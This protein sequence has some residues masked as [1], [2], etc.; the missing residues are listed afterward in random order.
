VAGSGSESAFDDDE[1]LC[2]AKPSFVD[3]MRASP[4]VGV[5]LDLER[6]TSPMRDAKL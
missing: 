2:G 4:F 1:R 6:D 3:F 5:A